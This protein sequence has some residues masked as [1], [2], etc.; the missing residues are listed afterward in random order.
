MFNN[1]C[2]IGPTGLQ[3]RVYVHIQLCNTEAD[4][5]EFNT[6]L[7]NRKLPIKSLINFISVYDIFGVPSFFNSWDLSSHTD[8]Q[9]DQQSTWLVNQSIYVY[10]DLLHTFAKSWSVSMLLLEEC[11][12]VGMCGCGHAHGKSERQ[13]QP[14]TE[15]KQ[16]ALRAWQGSPLQAASLACRLSASRPIA[17]TL[18]Q[19]VTH[20]DWMCL[21]LSVYAMNACWLWHLHKF[22]LAWP[23]LGDIFAHRK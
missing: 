12:K 8:G 13:M 19:S 11:S 16:C 5:H 20:T 9:M 1:F 10:I 22:L 3:F 6:F 4:N 2:V 21:C 15:Q 17:Q 23:G 7:K 18:N 14:G